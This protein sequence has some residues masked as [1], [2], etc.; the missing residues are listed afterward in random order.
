[1]HGD[2][3]EDAVRAVR[4]RAADD[5]A[6][7]A[8]AVLV[9]EHADRLVVHVVREARRSGR[10]WAEIAAVLEPSLAHAVV[11]ARQTASRDGPAGPAEEPHP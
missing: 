5:L 6:R 4:A 10:S 3:I 7:V 8:E 2:L 9:A 11:H 1:M